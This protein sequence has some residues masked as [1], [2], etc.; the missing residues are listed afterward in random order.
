MA[1]LAV[2]AGLMAG[3]TTAALSQQEY[4]PAAPEPGTE[5]PQSTVRMGILPYADGSFPIIGVKQ[6]FFGDVGISISP[7][8]GTKVTEEQAH[9]LLMRGDLDVTHGYPPNFL[10]TYQNSRVVKQIMFHDVIVAGCMLASPE[11]KLKGIKD[12]LAEGMPFDKAIAEAMA[13]VQGKELA[14]TP[15]ANERLFEDTITQL[16]GVTWTPKILDDPNIL[17]S[18]KA[19]Q[20][21]FAH[22]SG[23]P[24]VYSLLQAGWTRL[25]CLDDLIAHGPK[26]KDSPILR[27]ITAVGAEANG[28]WVNKNPNTALR[29]ISAVWRTIDAIKAD[30]A[31]Y[32]IQAPVLNSITGTNLT[33]KDLAGTVELFHPYITYGEN[34][35]FY[36]DEQSL[37]YY[38]PLYEQIIGAFAENGVVPA[39]VTPDE[40]VWGGKLWQQLEDYRKQTDELLGKLDVASLSQ[41]K[42]DLVTEARKFYGWHD[43]LDAYRFALAASQ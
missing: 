8:E 27:S 37:L 40:F 14:S 5:I 30:P 43:Y 38:K 21:Q 31:L 36:T 41:E 32:D 16:S 3:M 34:T 2:S 19:G 6:G 12:Y 29:Y 24:V 25:V 11:Q 18:A 26:G 28:E 20:I 13:P 39:D 1:A 15:V 7:A 33:G 9:S 42:K 35:R 4:K 23:A 22:P 17:V 10:P